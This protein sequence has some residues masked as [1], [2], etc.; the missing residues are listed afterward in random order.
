MGP[1]AV[2]EEGIVIWKDGMTIQAFDFVM[3]IIKMH[4]KECTIIKI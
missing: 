3:I 4:R 2:Q 1:I